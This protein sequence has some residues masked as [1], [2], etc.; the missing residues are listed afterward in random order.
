MKRT[1]QTNKQSNKQTIRLAN[2]QTTCV[3]MQNLQVIII[4]TIVIIHCIQIALF[5]YTKCF[6]RSHKGYSHDM[7][8]SPARGVG[9]QERSKAWANR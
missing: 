1:K 7:N 5:N 8:N 3:Q 2:N 9:G 6:A 4:I